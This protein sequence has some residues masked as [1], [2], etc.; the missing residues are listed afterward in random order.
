[1]WKIGR[2]LGKK[3]FEDF[4]TI[5]EPPPLAY[6]LRIFTFPQHACIISARIEKV[7][8]WEARTSWTPWSNAMKL[9]E[10]HE[11]VDLYL[12]LTLFV[13]LTRA[14][15]FSPQKGNFWAWEI[16]LLLSSRMLSFL[17]K[18]FGPLLV[19]YTQSLILDKPSSHTCT[20]CIWFKF[21]SHMRA[22]IWNKT[23]ETQSYDNRQEISPRK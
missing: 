19:S 18:L 4:L 5:S 11:Y 17:W 14:L 9:Q 16:S 7:T 13:C 3:K 12:N 15:L 20:L 1:M 8:A 10:N 22:R 6:Q 2:G 23:W 21:F